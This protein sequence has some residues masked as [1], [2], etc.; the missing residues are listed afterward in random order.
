MQT[1]DFNHDKAMSMLNKALREMKQDLD[2]V[3]DLSLK[4][5]QK[6]LAKH[7]HEIYEEVEKL[8]DQ[9]GQTHTHDDFNHV[10]RQLEVLKPAFVLNYNEILDWT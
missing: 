3:D 7:M 9:Y 8:V 2:K 4:G 1:S 6:K 5:V 10:C